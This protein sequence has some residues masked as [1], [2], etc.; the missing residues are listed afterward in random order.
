MSIFTPQILLAFNYLKYPLIFLG[1]LVEGP[2]LMV[3]L[4]F[5]LHTGFFSFWPLFTAL[6][7]GDLAGD[8]GWYYIGYFFAEPVLRKNGKFLSVTPETFGKIKTVFQRHHIWI[9]FFSKITLGLGMALGTLITAGASRVP[10]RSY[11][12]M[13]GLG[14]LFFV[15]TMLTLGYF[16]GH[17]THSFALGFKIVSLAG[18]IGFALLALYGFSRY[19]RS[20]MFSQ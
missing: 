18:A 19:A 7:L 10:F 17:L 16:F 3:T 15:G 6:V 12:L 2:M 20:R 5:L 8:V 1:A 11:L 14:E 9:L 13:N 4:G